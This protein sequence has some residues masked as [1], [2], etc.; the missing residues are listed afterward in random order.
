MVNAHLHVV[1]PGWSWNVLASQSVHGVRPVALY[2]PIGHVRVTIIVTGVRV[3]N[4]SD[5]KLPK[6]SGSSTEVTTHACS[7]MLA[8]FLAAGLVALVVALASKPNDTTE[9]R[10]S[11]GTC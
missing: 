10:P 1:L 2:V 4:T 7:R 5:A 11:P 8:A 3:T 6:L 9:A